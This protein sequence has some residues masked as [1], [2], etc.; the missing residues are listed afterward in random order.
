M[1]LSGSRDPMKGSTLLTFVGVVVIALVIGTTLGSIGFPT[2]KTETTTQTIAS[3]ST[4]TLF[5]T[6]VVTIVTNTSSTSSTCT[7]TGG[8]G[9]PHFF[10]ETFSLSVD[11]SGPWGLSYQGYLG[12]GSGLPIESGNFFGHGF[13]WNSSVTVSGIDE[14]GVTACAEA[15]KLDSSN[16]TLGLI[17]QGNANMTSLPYGTTK[18]CITYAII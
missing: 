12:D 14:Y 16:A 17:L 3:S 10:N 9:C 11:Y 13:G 15:Q 6:K 18:V 1:E 7:A 2:T 5:I 8:I 4:T